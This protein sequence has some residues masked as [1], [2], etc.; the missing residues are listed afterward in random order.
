MGS[1]K[2]WILTQLWIELQKKDFSGVRQMIVYILNNPFGNTCLH[3]Y[4]NFNVL[5]L[6]T[7]K[8][9]WCLKIL[10]GWMRMKHLQDE[11]GIIFLARNLD[12]GSLIW[13]LNCFLTRQ[14]RYGLFQVDIVFVGELDLVRS[15]SFH[16]VHLLAHVW[17]SQIIESNG[18]FQFISI[19]AIDY[20]IRPAVIL[21][22]VSLF[23]F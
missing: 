18:D 23:Y 3:Q 14:V 8:E 5:T 20:N 2:C 10:V 11:E 13:I 21:F 7:E 22:Q 9:H 17:R 4:S 15:W 16:I 6:G 1:Y 12:Q 19:L